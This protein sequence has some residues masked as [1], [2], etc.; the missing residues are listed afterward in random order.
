[1]QPM[2]FSRTISA[3][4]EKV[5]RSLTDVARYPA[6]LTKVDATELL[7]HRAFG[8]G[9]SWRETRRPYGWPVTVDLR[10]T[11]CQPPFRYVV[12]CFAGG[13]SVTEYR[14]V[15]CDGGR[16]TNLQLTYTLTG[17]SLIHRISR[18][19]ARRRILACIRENNVQDLLDIDRACGATA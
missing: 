11:D 15:P 19:L 2:T 18:I 12:E 5:W 4:P 3:P 8:P 14:L 7:H 6:L 9:T 1:M 17:G 13:H 10:V 16:G